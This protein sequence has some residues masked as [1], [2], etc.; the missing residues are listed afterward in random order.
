MEIVLMIFYKMMKYICCE[1]GTTN[2]QISEQIEIYMRDMSKYNN[3]K[4]IEQY[5]AK[6]EKKK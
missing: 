5:N 6:K 2:N 4:L 3:I 1:C